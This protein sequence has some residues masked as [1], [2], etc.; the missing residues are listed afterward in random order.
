MRAWAESF[1]SFMSVPSPRASSPCSALGSHLKGSPAAV[2]AVP[3]DRPE[4]PRRR[5]AYP[6]C[7]ARG[8]AQHH[9]QSTALVDRGQDGWG[10][11]RRGETAESPSGR[12]RR[13]AWEN[14]RSCVFDTNPNPIPR[15]LTCLSWLAAPF[16]PKWYGLGR[17]E[18]SDGWSNSPRRYNSANAQAARASDWC[19]PLKQTSAH[20]AER[21]APFMKAISGKQ[22]PVR[23]SSRRSPRSTRSPRAGGPETGATMHGWRFGR[24]SSPGQAARSG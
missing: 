5:L 13:V 15:K 10:S 22:R 23:W 7:S 4:S 17:I 8:Q 11:R 24:S 2:L 21:P 9:R 20:A 16:D 3:R 18:E 14:A 19:K 1:A 6:P 12:A